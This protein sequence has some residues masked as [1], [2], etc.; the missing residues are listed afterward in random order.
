VG[1]ESASGKTDDARDPAEALV[2]WLGDPQAQKASRV[3]NKGA[4]LGRMYNAGFNVPAGFCVTV[5]ALSC[6]RDVYEEAVTEALGKLKP[7]WVVRSS[8]TA[9]DSKSLAFPGLFTTL[10]DLA[11]VRSA[12]DAIEQVAESVNNSAVRSYAAYHDIA[13][14]EIQMAVLVQTMIPATAAGVSFSRDPLTG[15]PDVVIEANY[16][17]GETVVDGS[18]TPDSVTVKADGSIAERRT[19]SKRMKVIATTLDARVRRIETS[20]LERSNDVLS[21]LA[22]Q[23]IAQVTRDI[24]QYLDVAVDVEWA[25]VGEELHILQARPITAVSAP[26]DQTPGS[27]SP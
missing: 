4:T 2:L 7:A 9:E 1:V 19:G 14:D 22:A 18:I 5:S 6:G 3:G 21:D 27:P 11:D 15:A 16:G 12:L 17:L 8:S 24:E 26:A 23:K 13:A 20:P 10:L 25:F